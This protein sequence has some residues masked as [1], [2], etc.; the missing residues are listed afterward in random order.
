MYLRVCNMLCSLVGAPHLSSLQAAS[1]GR[2]GTTGS[3]TDSGC[4]DCRCWAPN[5]DGYGCAQ[6]DCGYVPQAPDYTTCTAGDA[7]NCSTICPSQLAADQDPASLSTADGL[8]E[9]VV[10]WSH[11]MAPITLYSGSDF[12][13]AT[14]FP[15][16]NPATVFQD[17]ANLETL[18]GIV[19]IAQRIA[20]VVDSL[21]ADVLHGCSLDN[22]TFS[23]GLQ[24]TFF[25]SFRGQLYLPASCSWAVQVRVLPSDPVSPSPTGNVGWWLTVNGLALSGSYSERL[26]GCST[27]RHCILRLDTGTTVESTQMYIYSSGLFDFALD[28]YVGTGSYAYLDVRV[29]TQTVADDPDPATFCE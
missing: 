13:P 19:P 25:A 7:A 8:L 17:L 2:T 15:G 9:T 28:Y 10:D 21:T 5:S 4:I 22:R 26:L 1:D 29:S 16:T 20:P 3:G 18:T 11:F 23:M 14:L 12:P 6:C 24:T 27:A